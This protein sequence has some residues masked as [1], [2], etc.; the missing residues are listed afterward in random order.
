MMQKNQELYLCFII[1]LTVLIP[2]CGIAVKNDASPIMHPIS[3]ATILQKSP[4]PV[5]TQTKLP[6]VTPNATLNPGNVEY[7]CINISE[8]ATKLND[9]G[10]TLVL[11]GYPGPS[12]NGKLISYSSVLV[13]MSS[14][15]QIPLLAD[16]STNRFVVSPSG[17]YLA[18]DT[19]IRNDYSKS[20]I[21]ILDANGKILS[22]IE[23]EQVLVFMEWLNDKTLLVNSLI[24]HNPMIFLS[25]FDQRQKIV[26]PFIT[27]AERIAPFDHELLLQW[28]F[29]AYHKIIYNP[30]LPRA[31]YAASDQDG[32]KAVFRD[33]TS[34]KDISILRGQAWGVSPK[35]SPDGTK[36]AIGK[37]TNSPFETIKYELVILDQN[38]EQLF[39][40]HLSALPTPIDISSLSWSPDGNRVAFWYT[41][42]GDINVNRDFRLAIFD[43]KTQKT[44]DYCVTKHAENHRWHR[45]DISPIWSPDGNFLLI[46]TR[47]TGDNNANVVVVDLVQEYAAIVKTGYE[48]VGWMR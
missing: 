47:D 23:V 8:D 37:N 1:L 12:T 43:T 26:E 2:G 27:E 30:T 45:N 24:E 38:G 17:D 28:G 3:S 14:G 41:T 11:N 20:Q 33:L 9:M 5:E 39:T 19:P 6:V 10:G 35:W 31:V 29:Y 22:R 34:N 4:V 46:E 7:H 48:P 36:F 15:N 13:D 18:F 21:N 16:D 25:P 44:I 32:A 42:N 40:T